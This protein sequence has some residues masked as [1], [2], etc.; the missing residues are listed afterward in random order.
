MVK[1]KEQGIS[2]DE[3][4]EGVRQELIRNKGDWP[5]LAAVSKGSITYRWIVAFSGG[6]IKDPQFTTLRRV[7]SYL[8]MKIRVEP[9]AHYAKFKP[10]P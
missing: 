8:G 1:K 7:A 2:G 5:R 10:E 4:V 9:G 6:Q 3:I